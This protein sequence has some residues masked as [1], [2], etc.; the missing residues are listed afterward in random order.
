MLTLY[1]N[2]E[3]KIPS[4]ISASQCCDESNMA[5][6]YTPSFLTMGASSGREIDKG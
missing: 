4:Y 1:I 3:L 6:G 2:N 5:F